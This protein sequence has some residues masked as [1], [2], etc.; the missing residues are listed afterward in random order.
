MKLV[1]AIIVLLVGVVV[2]ITGMNMMSSGLKKATGKSVKRLF[3][4]TQNS[5]IVGLGIGLVVTALIQ[6]SAA[7]SVMS[8]GFINA[9][10]MSVFQGVSIMMGAYIGT[11]MTGILV[12][13]S[14][15]NITVFLI[16][17]AVIGLVLMFFKKQKWRGTCCVI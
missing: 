13:L 11:T 17:F 5:S 16:A 8:I 2:F 7:T 6:S 4:K 3:K 12:S 9:G 14:S 15:F 1:E 10:V